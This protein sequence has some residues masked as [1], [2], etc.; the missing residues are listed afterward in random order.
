MVVWSAPWLFASAAIAYGYM[1]PQLH[2]ATGNYG[3]AFAAGL[4]VLTLLVST[5]IQPVAKRLHSFAS[6]RG[7]VVSLWSVAAGILLVSAA[8]ALQSLWWGIAACVVIGA[9][10]GTGLVPGLL[11]TQQLASP[12]DLAA[13]T[14]IFYAVAYAGFLA[15]TVIAALGQSLPAPLVLLACSG[16]CVLVTLW[17]M[18]ASRRYPPVGG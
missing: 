14:G 4:T 18:R 7:L 3:L 8:V 16:G 6:A 12:Q 13:L 10:L 2:S 5:F 11:E 17:V 9:A 1:P 15:P